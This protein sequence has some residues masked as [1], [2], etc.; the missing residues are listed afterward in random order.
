MMPAPDIAAVV[1]AHALEDPTREVCGLIFTDLP[2]KR[3]LARRCANVAADPGTDWAIATAEWEAAE[4]EAG[5]APALTYHSHPFTGA[6]FTP[7]DMAWAEAIG[8][9]ALLYAVGPDAFA[10]Y[11]PCGYE[12]PYEGRPF[13]WGVLDCW[14]LARDW[15]RREM[16]LALASPP[17][18]PGFWREG[19]IFVRELT[20]G[21]FTPVPVGSWRR[22]DLLLFA[23]NN[24]GNNPDG[25]ANHCA[26]IVSEECDLILNHV[27]KRKS[28]VQPFNS[29]RSPWFPLLY[30]YPAE[31]CWRPP[32]K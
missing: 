19:D 9:P 3:T 8:T 30:R 1:R 17:R 5:C 28:A 24:G 14:A 31:C 22:G 25:V 10:L 4:N 7:A 26:V 2:G 21:G 32:S 15:Y 6:E 18:A 11:E 29:A 16:G 13:A 27:E 12:L 23:I 20:A